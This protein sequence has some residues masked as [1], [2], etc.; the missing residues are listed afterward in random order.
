[1]GFFRPFRRV[2]ALVPLWAILRRLCLRKIASSRFFRTSTP[3]QLYFISAMWT[4]LVHIDRFHKCGRK[5]SKRD[6]VGAPLLFAVLINLSKTGPIET[7]PYANRKRRRNAWWDISGAALENVAPK[8]PASI[9]ANLSSA[10]RLV[11]EIRSKILKGMKKQYLEGKVGFDPTDQL[12]GSYVHVLRPNIDNAHASMGHVY[13]YQGLIDNACGDADRVAFVVGHELAHVFAQHGQEIIGHRLQAESFHFAIEWSCDRLIDHYVWNRQTWRARGNDAPPDANRE[14]RVACAASLV[15]KLLMHG[16][17]RGG[18]LV[19]SVLP[20]S[21]RLEHE[22]DAIGTE[23]AHLGGYCRMGGLKRF[24]ETVEHGS[25]ASTHPSRES[26][27]KNLW[28]GE[29]EKGNLSSNYIEPIREYIG[30]FRSTRLGRHFS[31]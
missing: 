28:K 3:V 4:V 20:L 12:K 22:A 5:L 8:S 31:F 15:M 13:I 7:I 24:A 30:H 1:M 6:L 9:F 14:L 29:Y 21:R 27:M 23:L 19:L 16:L 17:I 11:S 10:H 26:R 2:A 25:F 18:G